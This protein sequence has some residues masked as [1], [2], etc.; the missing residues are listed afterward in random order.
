[1]YVHMMSVLLS[2]WL[3]RKD[4]LIVCFCHYGLFRVLCG[5]IA[6]LCTQQLTQNMG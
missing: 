3:Q 2:Q 1:M 4:N 6:I 5:G